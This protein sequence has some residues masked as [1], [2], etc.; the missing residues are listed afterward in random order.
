MR[1]SYACSEADI[2]EGCDR[3]ER[4]LSGR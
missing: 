1:L 3:L 4:F 2:E